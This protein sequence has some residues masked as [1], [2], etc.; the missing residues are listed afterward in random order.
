MLRIL[1]IDPHR[2]F[3]RL[4]AEVFEETKRAETRRLVHVEDAATV[5]DWKPTVV[6]VAAELL[7]SSTVLPELRATL[8][9][10]HYVVGMT[11][12]DARNCDVECNRVVLKPFDPAQLLK[13]IEYQLAD[14]KLN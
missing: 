4:L 14:A 5:R 11:T 3:A 9:T 10:L 2:D 7:N 8:P 12:N 13:H 1:I 6:L